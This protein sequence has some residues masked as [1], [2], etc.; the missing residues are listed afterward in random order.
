MPCSFLSEGQDPSPV[1]YLKWFQG[2]L[3]SC[4]GA[5]NLILVVAL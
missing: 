5:T 1:L 2:H 3:D 4:P